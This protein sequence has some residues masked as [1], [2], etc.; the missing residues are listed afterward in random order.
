MK[1]RLFTMMLAFVLSSAMLS[2]CGAGGGKNSMRDEA[3]YTATEEAYDYAY[4]AEAGYAEGAAMGNTSSSV[5]S[6]EVEQSAE[7][8]NRKLIRT[9]NLTVET[10]EF[11]N[12]TA[13]LSSEI[14]A[15]GGYIENMEGSYGSS[16]SSYRSSKS[17][18]IV[19]RIPAK[20]LD[21]FLQTVG[22]KSN[23]TYRSERTDDVTLQYVDMDSHKRMLLE[24]QERLM[25]F[26]QQAE[27]IED[28]ISIE[29]RLTSVK[30]D[31]ESM[32]SQLRTF[33]NKV[34]Y[35][36]VTISINEVVDYTVTVE[37]EKTPVERMKE[38]FVRSLVNVGQGLREFG[39]WFVIN[40][41]Y[42][43]LL[44]ILT[45]S[46]IIIIRF[47]SKIEKKKLDKIK[48]ERATKANLKGAASENVS[49][50]DDVFVGRPNS[51]NEENK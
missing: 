13:A 49:Q 43:I 44:A 24:E 35:S 41:P 25:E 14:T 47:I 21:E 17:A 10:K 48:A 16:Y 36:T 5:S 28:I 26:L 23:I 46:I 11:D 12:L 31:L 29:S 38:G 42:F 40:I 22:E 1:K 6:S 9:V 27:T 8:G 45:V 37:P 19:A 32:E 30:Y 3:A 2:A 18:T 20:K 33:D 7:S 51:G 15:L 4:P 34:D 50:A 39:I